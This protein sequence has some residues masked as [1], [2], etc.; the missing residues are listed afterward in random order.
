MRGGLGERHTL[1]HR[2]VQSCKEKRREELL[3]R[4]RFGWTERG[5]RNDGNEGGG[6]RVW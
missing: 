5:G 1:S 4:G 3:V 6:V 2:I